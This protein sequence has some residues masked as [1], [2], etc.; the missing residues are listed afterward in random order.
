MVIDE[1]LAK[2]LAKYALIKWKSDYISTSEKFEKSLL[3]INLSKRSN[4]EKVIN[5]HKAHFEDFY[6]CYV[7]CGSKRKPYVAA[8]GLGYHR[9]REFKQWSETSLLGLAELWYLPGWECDESTR[10]S[11]FRVGEHAL[12][13]VFQ[14]SCLID[15]VNDINYKLIISEFKYLAIWVGFWSQLA[16]DMSTLSTQQGSK[17]NPIV[18]TPNGLLLCEF[19]L[20]NNCHL[21][22]VRTYV[23]KNMLD[24]S[25]AKIRQDMIEASND[26]KNSMLSLFPHYSNLGPA[27]QKIAYVIF[28]LL[29]H[30]I[31]GI[32]ALLSKEILKLANDFEVYDFIRKLDEYIKFELK[33]VDMNTFNEE[34]KVMG[35]E[36]FSAYAVEN[37][38]N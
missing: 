1:T 23:H 13:R 25:Q 17:L 37:H 19:T 7:K 16:N 10:G 3:K 34:F 21:M 33:D 36:S 35:Y 38:L 26:I 14:R 2:S 27:A 18:P 9:D 8:M 31:S 28:Q 24:E 22:E 32:T 11:F 5:L 6:F 4:F 20:I 29:L 15:N 30:R 12:S